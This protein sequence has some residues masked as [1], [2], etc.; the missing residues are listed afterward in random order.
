MPTIGTLAAG[1]T[2]SFGQ[3]STVAIP[4][5]TYSN[6]Y[7]QNGTKTLSAGTT[8]VNGNLTLDG[9][10]NFNGAG[11]P[12]STLNLSGN[13]TM[14]NGSTF[15]A[16]P[17][18]DANRLTLVLTGSSAQVLS[19]GNIELFRLQTLST[20]ATSLQIILSSANVL[21]GNSTGGGLNLQQPIHSMLLNN[22]TLTIRGAGFISSTN[23]GMLWGSNNANLVIDKTAGSSAI[24]AIGFDPNGP[25]LNNLTVNSAGTGSNNFTLLSGLNIVGTLTL[26]SGRVVV[27]EATTLTTSA[28][29]GSGFGASKHIV[30]KTNASNSAKGFLNLNTPAATPV[31]FPVGDGTNYLPATITA[32]SGNNFS[33][34]AFSG[35]TRDGEPGGIPFSTA[36]K[37]DAVDAVWYIN[38]GISTGD[39]TLTT[40]W[41]SSLEGASFAALADNQI[42][43]AHYGTGWETSVGTGDNTANT[44]TRTGITTFSPFGVGLVGSVLPVNLSNVKATQQSN[45]IKVEWSNMTELD[46]VSYGIERSV[47]GRNFVSVGTVNARLNNGTRSD[48]SFI[49]ANPFAAINYYRIRTL[50]SSGKTKYS[51]IVKVDIRSG[52]TLLV[53]YPNPVVD[54]QLS[55]QANNLAKGKYTIRIVNSMGQQVYSK[56]LNHGGGS[57]SEAMSLPVL[58]A[59]IY[60]LQLSSDDNKFAKTFVVQ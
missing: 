36:Q 35:I 11:S 57:V 41:P 27:T 53:L 31:S 25:T 60:S 14:T 18:G 19:G 1:S 9:V 26:T 40:S 49:D 34:C 5:A 59:G 47:D 3:S 8:T 29:A 2:V 6:L 56:T 7:L 37:D 45:S 4:A 39:A 43:I 10:T 38:R 17:A 52:A 16:S 51:I 21:L 30:T 28:I 48:Y 46:M 33:V 55:Y 50:E 13:F 58:K 54:G 20:P 42:G 32:S 12:F 44:A 15:E 24:G 23:T 22:N